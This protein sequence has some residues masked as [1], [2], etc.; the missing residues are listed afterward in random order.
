MK[1]WTVLQ[2]LTQIKRLYKESWETFIG[3]AGIHTFFGNVDLF[4]TRVC[5][6]KA[7]QT[8]DAD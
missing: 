8:H 7:R 5:I 6:Q 2:D 3:N 4:T 1:L